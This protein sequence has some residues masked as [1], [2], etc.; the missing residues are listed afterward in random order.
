VVVAVKI[1]VLVVVVV[2]IVV[3]ECMWGVKI[4]DTNNKSNWNHLRIIQTVPQQHTGKAQNQGP[5]ENSHIGHCIHTL[6]STNLNVQ[7]IQ[8]EK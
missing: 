1:V 6:G 2:V 3:I 4:S 8:H 7:N 5:T